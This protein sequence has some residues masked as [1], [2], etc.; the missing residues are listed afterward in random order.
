MTYINVTINKLNEYET[1]IKIRLKTAKYT[2]QCYNM[3]GK[4]FSERTNDYGY[5]KILS[6]SSAGFLAYF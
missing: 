1:K 5:P 2:F 6:G 3:K 4:V